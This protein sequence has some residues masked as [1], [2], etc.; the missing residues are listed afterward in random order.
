MIWVR[1]KILGFY[2]DVVWGY[3]I[4][5]MFMGYSMSVFMIVFVWWMVY[6]LV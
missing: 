3:F 6:W 5:R 1:S 4:W 2:I